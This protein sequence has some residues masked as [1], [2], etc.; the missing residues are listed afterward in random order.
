MPGLLDTR[1]SASKRE[2]RRSRSVFG[3]RRTGAGGVA[4]TGSHNGR[5]VIRPACGLARQGESPLSWF[6]AQELLADRCNGLTTFAL[7]A[8]ASLCQSL[9]VR[10]RSVQV[11]F[12]G[13]LTRYST[14]CFLGLMLVECS[15][16][17]SSVSPGII[18]SREHEVRKRTARACSPPARSS[19]TCISRCPYP[20]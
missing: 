17:P 1:W 19:F 12:L 10:F 11:Q 8:G 2:R 15:C 9:L 14:Y 7:S 16:L 5:G 13:V 4:L 20:R 3:L 6:S 18:K